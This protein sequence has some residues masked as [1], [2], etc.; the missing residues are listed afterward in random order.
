[1]LGGAAV[2][3]QANRT[4]EEV[5]R[6]LTAHRADYVKGDADAWAA[7]YAEDALVVGVANY[8]RVL[9]GR[10][11]IREYVAQ[12]MREFPTRTADPSN[13]R[14]RVYNEKTT[15]TVITT[16]DDHGS[17]TDAAGR[18][19]SL[20]FRETLVWTK[21]QGKWLIVTHQ[22]SPLPAPNAAQ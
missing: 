22:A 12:V 14:V 21:I 20:N 17:R 1:M 3:G 13:I 19:V 18:K 15:P 11:A 8:Q 6:L 9:E 5:A 2:Q 10:P 7:M 4:A 16:L